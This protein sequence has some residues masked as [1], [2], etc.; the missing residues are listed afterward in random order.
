M[1]TTNFTSGTV[2]ASDWLNDV[3]AATYE[4]AAV[5]TPAGTGAVSRTVQAKLRD[6]V[7]VK[8]FGA[9]GDGSTD[10]T[11]AFNDAAAA[12]NDIEVPAGTFKLDTT[13]TTT[14]AVLDVGADAS[15]TGSGGTALGYTASTKR[16]LLQSGTAGTDFALQYLRRNADHTGGSV[17]YVSSSLRA[18]TYVA[19][20]VTNFEWA[21][22]GVVDNSATAGENVGGYFQGIKRSG[23]GP[24]WGAVLEVVDHN[25]NP[26]SAVV[27][28]EIDVSAN[29]G[30]SSSNR[31]GSDMAIRKRDTGGAAPTVGWG[32]R[33]Q[34]EASATLNKGF[35]FYT[36]ST[37]VVG[38][39]TS[40]ATITQAAY[41]MAQSQAIA[42]NAGAT[43][44]LSH[45]GSGFL[46]ANNSGT[47]YWAL[48]D[49]FSLSNNGT[50]V[51]G[52]RQ[53]GYAAMTGTVNR[54]AVYDTAT[55]TLA[56]LAGRV[57]ALQADLTL[58]GLVG[59]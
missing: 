55:V 32:Y 42:F 6:T 36:G 58:H 40:E 30:D 12:W 8:D 23:A 3:D 21:V 26:A 24:T 56:Q 29:G 17:G 34:V 27:G 44:Q 7:S 46:F 1:S 43:R 52:L 59:A 57:M 13:P 25:T 18:I 37:V 49:N 16:Q 4:G 31:V 11:T 22:V 2:I 51:L 20:G 19:A 41:K 5:F 33:V 28:V 48:N 10:D 35:G 15:L 53:T 45:N 14:G 54:A 9:V 47:T 50:Q 38:F 39:D